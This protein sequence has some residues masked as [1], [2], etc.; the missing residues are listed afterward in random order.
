MLLCCQN[1]SNCLARAFNWLWKRELLRFKNWPFVLI[2]EQIVHYNDALA[3]GRGAPREPCID[4]DRMNLF[5]QSQYF[6]DRGILNNG[7]HK[8]CRRIEGFELRLDEDQH[9]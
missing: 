2:R 4:P 9:V 8:I 3:L 1:E 7:V 5:Q 6:R